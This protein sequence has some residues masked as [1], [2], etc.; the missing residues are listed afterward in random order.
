MRIFIEMFLF[1]KQNVDKM[2]K[3]KSDISAKCIYLTEL[4]EAINGEYKLIDSQTWSNAEG[5]RVIRDFGEHWSGCVAV[6]GIANANCH[7]SHRWGYFHS[8]LT[9]P[10]SN[11]DIWNNKGKSSGVVDCK[12]AGT[13]TWRGDQYVASYSVKGGTWTG[14]SVA[15]MFDNDPDTMWHN[16]ELVVTGYLTE[17]R[18]VTISFLKAIQLSKVSILTRN[19]D[20]CTDRYDNVCLYVDDVKALCTAQNF[21]PPKKHQVDFIKTI[22]GTKFELRFE[23]KDTAQIAELWIDYQ[24]IPGILYIHP[25]W[26]FVSCILRV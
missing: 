18:G 24:E 12:I 16:A 6:N 8:D 21:L 19:S 25:I 5:N 3:I 4:D 22:Y 17:D 2:W 10:R 9:Q 23:G 7:P 14:L 13:K 1:R 15:S 11:I 20:C 26:S